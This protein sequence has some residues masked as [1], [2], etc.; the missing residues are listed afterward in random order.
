MLPCLSPSAAFLAPPTVGRA[1]QVADQGNAATR[2]AAWLAATR[3]GAF[4]RKKEEQPMSTQDEFATKDQLTR[5]GK[6]PIAEALQNAIAKSGKAYYAIERLTG[7]KRQS[8]MYF[9]R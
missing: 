9:M 8:I 7:V 4:G 3:A 1:L 6:Q 2:T 5:T